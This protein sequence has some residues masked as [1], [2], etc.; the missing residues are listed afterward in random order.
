ML[1]VASRSSAPRAAGEARDEIDL[2]CREVGVGA[3]PA[4][5]ED[6]RGALEPG[7]DGRG[8]AIGHVRPEAAPQHRA[9]VDP[10]A[11]R[12]S[13]QA[14][15]QT[16]RAE[17]DGLRPAGGAGGEAD[18]DERLRRGPRRRQQPTGLGRLLQPCRLDAERPDVRRKGPR[19]LPVGD[20]RHEA[21]Q[22][23]DLGLEAIGEGHRAR[24][25]PHQCEQHHPVARRPLHV[26][27]DELARSD[28]RPEQMA[29]DALNVV[30]EPRVG[31]M[32]PPVVHRHR[33]RI[34]RPA[35]MEDLRQVHR[36]PFG[37]AAAGVPGKKV[38]PEEAGRVRKGVQ[39]SVRVVPCDLPPHVLNV[40][41]SRGIEVERRSEH[42]SARRL[43][44]EVGIDD[45]PD[46]LG[47]VA[48][49]PGT[50][51]GAARSPRSRRALGVGP[52]ERAHR[53]RPVAQRIV[54]GEHGAELEAAMVGIGPGLTPAPDSTRS[55]A[56]GGAMIAQATPPVFSAATRF[57]R[58]SKARIS[59]SR[60]RSAADRR[61]VHLVVR[62]RAHLRQPEGLVESCR[63]GRGRGRR[64]PWRRG[65]GC[66]CSP[67]SP[68]PVR[69]RS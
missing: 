39:H 1:A 61:A 67:S 9:G 22:G 50:F 31:Q 16:L 52:Q 29:G 43:G 19:R 20:H 65:S 17:L 26:E 3:A 41:L 36:W 64:R 46:D 58:V 47:G 4:E 12:R 11:P 27:P 28:P 49:R 45:T 2:P 34:E 30:E 23:G 5:R 10:A 14:G 63:A 38:E 42:H 54:R 62:R 32:V 24:P 51:P 35:G 56:I 18:A 66:R 69:P 25:E 7:G 13:R 44:R 8:E 40:D 6:H 48:R 53:L 37:A 33:V 60:S 57:G 15:V 21:V 55:V 59:R 68:G